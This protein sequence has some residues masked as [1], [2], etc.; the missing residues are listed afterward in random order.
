MLLCHP[1]GL[2]KDMS[3]VGWGKIDTTS[4]WVLESKL[5]IIVGLAEV[6]NDHQVVKFLKLRL[7]LCS[8]RG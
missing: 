5:A 1:F 8:G 6:K 7:G 3:F 2:R 4:K